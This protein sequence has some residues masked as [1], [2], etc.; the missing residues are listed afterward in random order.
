MLFSNAI[1]KV[2]LLGVIEGKPNWQLIKG[3]RV[4]CFSFKTTE[5]FKS[6]NITQSH[7][8]WHNIV[9]S[10]D[11]ARKTVDTQPRDLLHIQG[12]LQ[13]RIVMEGNVKRHLCEILA[14]DVTV[15]GVVAEDQKL[16]YNGAEIIQKV[17]S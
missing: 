4:L 1:N 3:E 14:S 2:F 9:I 16:V 15:C 5:E 12:K 6:G 10:G 11:L 13:T 17:K 7:S 8:E